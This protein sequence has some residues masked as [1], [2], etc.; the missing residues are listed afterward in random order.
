MRSN[1]FVL[2]R[3]N[4]E[5]TSISG[6][7]LLNNLFKSMQDLNARWDMT[8]LRVH[9]ISAFNVFTFM[10]RSSSVFLFFS[11]VAGFSELESVLILDLNV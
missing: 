5:A 6:N 9:R 11:T 4:F 10:I 1:A 8:T 7:M 3:V 2:P